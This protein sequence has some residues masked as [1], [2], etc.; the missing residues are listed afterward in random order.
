MKIKEINI[1]KYGPLENKSYKLGNFTL[2]YGPNESGKTMVVDA[3]VKFL[4]GKKKG[5]LKAFDSID[6]VE[7]HPEGYLI[8]ENDG[9]ELKVSKG[10]FT[11]LLNIH[12]EELRGVI[13][14]RNSDLN[15]AKELKEKKN[16]YSL[17]S[18]K[19]VGTKLSK[20]QELKKALLKSSITTET[21]KLK[22]KE[23]QNYKEKAETAQQS[24]EDIERLL[25][26]LH[27][28]GYDNI[29]TKLHNLKKQ[30]EECEIKLE[31][32]NQ[33]KKKIAYEEC[34]TILEELKSIEINMDKL[35][36]Y[37]SEALQKYIN[38]ENEIKN[39]ESQ[40][41]FI[42]SETEKAIEKLN[43]VADFLR[44]K[45]SLL[46][47]SKIKLDEVNK[48]E[49]QIDEYKNEY[50]RKSAETKRKVK[51]WKGIA[52]TSLTVALIFSVLVLLRFDTLPLFFKLSLMTAFSI[53]SLVSFTLSA[54]NRKQIHFLAK[55]E[56][57]LRKHG[58]TIFFQTFDT[59]SQLEEKISKFKNEHRQLEKE[60]TELEVQESEWKKKKN[61][62][63]RKQLELI[64]AIS[65]A[66][67][68]LNRIK[69][70]LNVENTEELKNNI[71]LRNKLK[72]RQE[73]LRGKLVQN[74]R[75]LNQKRIIESE[76]LET[77]EN[78][79]NEAA[80]T[81]FSYPVKLNEKDMESLQSLSEEKLKSEC[82]NISE[83]IEKLITIQNL[84]QNQ[85]RDI[86]KKLLDVG[87]NECVPVDD[88]NNLYISDMERIIEGLKKYVEK[89]R[90]L[91]EEDK[92]A[93]AILEEIE[94]EEKENIASI[95]ENSKLINIFHELTDNKYEL[96]YNSETTDVIVKDQKSQV[97][98][99]EQL[100]AGTYDQL[101]FSI[102]LALAEQLFGNEKAF[103]ILDDPFIKYDKNR[104]KKQLEKLFEL[105]KQGWQFVYFTA[106]DE[107]L[108]TLERLNSTTCD[109]KMYDI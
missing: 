93:L 103:F 89:I 52:V 81:I 109:F 28:R 49:K 63:E 33:L 62:Y 1:K 35:S 102:R 72:N 41:Q 105:S 22:D 98:K 69:F 14:V 57:D 44:K 43:S 20:L 38:Q 10:E 21:G 25:N 75:I 4:L 60:I 99:P 47:E 85:M 83:T 45:E 23:G 92:L 7:E 46:R 88:I 86:V 15:V 12:Y 16:F 76:N 95:F 13:V 87:L 2:F 56:E 101:Y 42:K 77:F 67:T 50:E 65:K 59:Q 32:L 64:E 107:V 61:D 55:I 94:K 48:L 71:E 30:K 36:I 74:L 39:L 100:S 91:S 8:I 68:E 19:L 18:E 54:N 80:E 84:A 27:Q 79:L 11:E 37:S 58:G 29:E 90:T 17:T 96:M 5:Y 40:L 104:L 78:V 66:Q 6:R 108:E 31:K 53:L 9:K 82:K 34:K 73:N 24:I 51:V 106:K 70:S 3:I 26:D 97:L